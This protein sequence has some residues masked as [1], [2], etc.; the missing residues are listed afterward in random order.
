MNKEQLN[1]LQEKQKEFFRSGFTKDYR[2]RIA[3]LKLLKNIIIENESKIFKALYED[4]HKGQIESYTS[5]I[6]YV[7]NEINYTIKHLKC[8]MKSKRVR[9]SLMNQPAKSY[10]YSEPLGTVLIISPWNYPFALLFTPLIGAIAA[11][12]CV[13]LKPSEVSKNT[14][15]LIAQLIYDNF[16]EQYI[17]AIE[18]GAE[19]T[20]NL[21]SE[22]ID[23]I[24]FTGNSEVG[25]EIMKSASKYLIPVSLELGGKNPCI[26]DTDIDFEVTAKRIVWGKFFNAGQ[27]CISPD[28]LLVHHSIKD[29]F[30]QA[31]IKT[32]NEFHGEDINSDSDISHIINE[33][34]FDRLNSLLNDG[35]VIYGGKNKKK[36]L[37]ISPTLMRN[38]KSNSKILT[39]EIFGPILPIFTYVNLE[40]EIEKINKL[41]KPLSLYLFTNDKVKQDMIIQQTSSG[42]VCIN[43]TIHTMVSNTLSFGGVGYS[44]IGKYKGKA[45]FETFSH[46]KSVLKKSFVFDA[47]ISYPPYKTSLETIKKAFKFLY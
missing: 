33:K 30:V 36:S 21:I 29:K 18:G 27:T 13:I 38:I 34:H 32:I 31:L 11:G 8:W 7:I 1:I 14:S 41:H 20:Q 6:A 47:K 25:K 9:T 15:N 23:Y 28:Y 12:N 26:I 5:E 43:G 16:D 19:V 2:H 10:I 46:R 45:S 4:L 39:D 44:G 40:S 37:F 24:F 42:Q 22:K 3:V 17:S 35:E